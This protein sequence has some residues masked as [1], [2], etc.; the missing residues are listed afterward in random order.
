MRYIVQ[1]CTGSFSRSVLEAKE[2][3][4]KLEYCMQVLDV[5]KVIFGWAPD[6]SLNRTISRLL[7]DHQVEKYLWLPVFAEIQNQEDADPNENIVETAQMDV[8]KFA[9][10]T[11]EFA[12]QSSEKNIW[13]AV[14]VFDQLTD[15][16]TVDGV[17]LDRIRYA[18]AANSFSTLFGC[19]CPRC[20]RLYKAEGAD[21]ER[22]QQ[23]AAEGKMGSFLPE[24]LEGFTYRFSDPDINHLMCAKRKLI[25]GQVEKLVEIFHSRGLKVGAD[26]FA[27]AVADFVGQDLEALGT[28]ADF[29]KPMVYLRTNAPAGV[30]F[31][32]HG[33][34]EHIRQRLDTL[35]DGDTSGM[36]VTVR[37][38]RALKEKRIDVAPGVDVNRVEGLCSSDALYVKQFLE[39]LKAAG[40]EKAVLSWDIMH[41]SKEMIDVIADI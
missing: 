39:Q 11:F 5:E 10:D 32:L 31:E 23:I 7:D 35:W 36:E 1:L 26:T 3:V 13:H 4:R 24:E 30:P 38:M 27:P 22:L 8:S 29:I 16:Y 28:K 17:F 6:A 40:M 15:G 21:I 20:R 41:I 25:S 33:L 19:W 34:G 2:V 14:D 12:C 18:S 37:Q 9:G